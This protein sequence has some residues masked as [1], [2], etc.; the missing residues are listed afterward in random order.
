M[1]ELANVQKQMNKLVE[2]A[3]A[4]TDFQAPGGVG[5]WEPLADVYETEGTLVV[6]LEIPGLGQDQIDVR[7]DGD[8]LVVEGERRMDR[9]Q[10]GEHF[11]RVERS[12]GHFLR[13]FRLPSYV[14][15]ESIE[16]VYRDGVL[17]ITLLR[18]GNAGPR[19]I[20]VSVR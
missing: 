17:K 7:V 1:N 11:H 4:R 10:P 16:A 8:E 13:R 3:L 18:T 20:R 14:D 6:C 5:S 19:A 15:R 9:E 2:S 12:Y